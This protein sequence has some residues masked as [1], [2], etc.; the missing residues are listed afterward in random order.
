MEGDIAELLTFWFE[1]IG[2]SRWFEN[3]PETDSFI[4]SRYLA[5][6]EAA[7]QAELSHWRKTPFGRLAEII[8]L[9]QFSRNIYRGTAKAFVCDPMA[10]VLSQE[11]I[12]RKWDRELSVKQRAFAYLPFMHSESREIHITALTLFSFPGLEDNLRF[13]LLHKE[14]IDRFGR[15]PHR[16]KILGRVSTLEELEFLKTH[17]GF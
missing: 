9:D 7:A 1:E 12:E 6:H 3:N 17:P 11:M 14:I 4:K 15:Y 2:P 8:L 16:N 13:E 10:L 5:L